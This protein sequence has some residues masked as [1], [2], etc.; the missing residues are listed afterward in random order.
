MNYLV[1]T[2]FFL[3]GLI[4][5]SFLNVLILRY[6]TGRTVLGRSACFS[7]GTT[8]I[9]QDLV[10]VFS[11]LAIGGKCRSCGSKISI[12]Y[13]LVE[14]LTGLIFL[15]VFWQVG[16]RFG[17]ESLFYLIYYLIIWSLLIVILVYDLR[18]KIIPDG[19]VYT[20]AILA[21]VNFLAITPFEQLSQSSG[22]WELLAGPILFLPFFLVWSLSRGRLMGLGDGKLALGIGWMLGLAKGGTAIILGFWVGA[23]V[24]IILLI[25]SKLGLSLGGKPLTI[26]SE[27]PFA[28]FLILGILIV[29][30]TGFNLF[31]IGL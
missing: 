6:R 31:A 17:L 18:H 1:G 2:A 19:F 30:L 16:L 7:C 3:L 10:P 11:F 29:F 26:K 20:F 22:L 15:A 4:I 9:W 23:V 28:P 27:V 24:S 13:P 25:L 21:L 14:F 5:G 8:L 12:Q